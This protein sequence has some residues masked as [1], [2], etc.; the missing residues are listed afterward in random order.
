MTH[1][2]TGNEGAFA[3]QTAEGPSDHS[4]GRGN[5]GQGPELSLIHI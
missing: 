4:E 1:A 2:K 5:P 3:D